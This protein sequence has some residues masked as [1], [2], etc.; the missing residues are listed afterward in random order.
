MERKL[1]VKRERLIE[2]SQ[3]ELAHVVAAGD[4]QQNSLTACIATLHGCTTAIECP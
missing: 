1:T 4:V 3:N 2:L